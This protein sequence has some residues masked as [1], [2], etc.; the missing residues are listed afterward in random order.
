MKQIIIMLTVCIAFIGCSTNYR[1][2][3]YRDFDKSNPRIDA[4]IDTDNDYIGLH[5]Y[6]SRSDSIIY[7]NSINFSINTDDNYTIPKIKSIKTTFLSPDMKEFT[8]KQNPFEVMSIDSQNTSIKKYEQLFNQ[9]KYEFD[10]SFDPA[11]RYNENIRAKIFVI[12]FSNECIS[13]NFI[14]YDYFYVKWDICIDEKGVLK[15]YEYIGKLK[16]V[17]KKVRK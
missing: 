9:R 17:N 8:A 3:T 14:K 10:P 15:N 1:V 6:K 13:N 2:K 16:N 5:F 11:E 7:S 12:D 4:S